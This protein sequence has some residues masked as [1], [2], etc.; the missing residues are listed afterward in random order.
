MLHLEPCWVRGVLAEI[1]AHGGAI[2]AL[3][4]VDVRRE[5]ASYRAL[6]TLGG[7]LFSPADAETKEAARR[8]RPAAACLTRQP[9]PTAP[10]CRPRGWRT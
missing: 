5:A 10:C 1:A 7:I 9:A 3:D 2:D 8:G 4:E 6:R